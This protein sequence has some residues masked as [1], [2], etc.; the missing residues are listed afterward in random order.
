MNRR[1]AIKILGAGAIAGALATRIPLSIS[2]TPPQINYSNLV[3]KEFGWAP[4]NNIHIYYEIYGSG[5]PLI[6]IMGY[7]GNLESWGP[8]IINGLASQY[9]V[10]IFD[11]RGTGRSGTVGQDPLHDAL[12]YTIPLYASDTI[13]LLN[14]LGYSNL[15]VLGWSMGGFVAQ[16]IA[17]DYPSYVNKLVLLC[18][19]PNIY[20]YPPKV[21][22]QSIITG[23]TASD[24]TVTVETII[25]YLV[26]SDW[27][28]AHPDVAK[29]VL[30]TLEKYP[31]SYTSVLK[32]TNA[33]AT[34]NS[35][36]QLQNITAPTLVIGGDSDLLLP[37]QNSQ[38]LAEN[39]PNAQLYIFS[40]DAGHGL[41]YQY[42]T[43]FI[44]L[45]TSFLG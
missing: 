25:P 40:P 4:V 9:E 14:Y 16:Q 30:F 43:Q 20:L 19:A 38:Y 10:I 39:I 36:G 23:F 35:V 15:N 41:I 44:N 45:V 33:L 5:E 2:Q 8:I 29:Y 3:P 18:T 21:S 42:P 27:L 34:F 1:D 26:P 24:P 7:L 17:I 28:Q 6:M 13:G 22:P 37:P 32:Q 11:N 31:I 12:T